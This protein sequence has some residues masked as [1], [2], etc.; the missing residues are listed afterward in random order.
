MNIAY[1]KL[2]NALNE[3]VAVGKGI[4]VSGLRSDGTGIRK[5]DLP[6]TDRGTKKWVGEFPVLSDNYD[7]YALAMEIFGPEY[8][9]YAQEYINMFGGAK[10]VRSPKVVVPKS[11]PK[12]PGKYGRPTAIPVPIQAGIQIPRPQQVVVQPR[13]Q[14]VVVQQRPP[15]VVQ[16]RARQVVSPPIPPAPLRQVIAQPPRQVIASPTIPPPRTILPVLTRP[17]SPPR[18]LSPPKTI[19]PVLTRP[20]S[21]KPV[22]IRPV[23]PPRTLSPPKVPVSPVSPRPASPTRIQGAT[24]IPTINRTLAL[25]RKVP[26]KINVPT[27]IGQ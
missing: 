25:G 6:R 5:I 22:L 1:N 18:T 16:P 24:I 19:L 17:A 21:P 2:V 4:D 23:S 20:A 13:P 11:P 8:Y 12:S 26:G 7:S 14:Q 10:I 27:V 15:Q 9:G 3:A